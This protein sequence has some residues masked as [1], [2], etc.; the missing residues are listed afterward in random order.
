MPVSFQGMPGFVGPNTSTGADVGRGLSFTRLKGP[1]LAGQMADGGTSG[2]PIPS[3]GG[4][5]CMQSTASLVNQIVSTSSAAI[6]NA[7]FVY[8]PVST[9][10][11]VSS[12]NASGQGSPAYLGVGTP[13]VWNDAA[14]RLMIWSSGLQSWLSQPAAQAFTCSS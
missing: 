11:F 9:G 3:A 5:I 10:S 13:I 14:Q 2:G 4:Y 7:S 8:I 12:N 6:T 1:A